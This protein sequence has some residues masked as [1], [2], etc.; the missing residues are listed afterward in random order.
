M[1]P[2]RFFLLPLLLLVAST[3]WARIAGERPVSDPLYGLAPGG[4][5]PPVVATDGDGFLTVWGDVRSWPDAIYAARL[6][7]NGELLDPTDIRIALG[8]E[9]SVVF[10][11]DA[12]SILWLEYHANNASLNVARVSREGRIVDGP[13][14]VADGVPFTAFTAATNG[15]R[16]VIA[17]PER[18]YVLS[19]HSELLE[20]DI[21]IQND[22]HTPYCEGTPLA[23]S[24]GSGFLLA[25]P[26]QGQIL[27][28]ALDANGHPLSSGV[29]FDSDAAVPIALTTDGSNY[30]VVDASTTA[31]ATSQQLSASGALLA[32]NDL[33]G[34]LTT[35]PIGLA[36]NG[37]DYVGLSRANFADAPRVTLRLTWSGFVLQLPPSGEEVLNRGAV[38]SNGHTLFAAWNGGS[39]TSAAAILTERLD[40]STLAATPPIAISFSATTQLN[41]SIA[42]SGT[43]YAV[44]W[45]EGSRSWL[46]RFSLT[47]DP[48]DA[49]PVPLDTVAASSTS[50]PRIT[51]DGKNY[52]AAA[53]EDTVPRNG[54]L[55]IRLTRID[56]LTG[57]I[58]S[59]FDGP[60]AFV[61]TTFDLRSDGTN[62]VMVWSQPGELRAA[63]IGM[64][65]VVNQNTLTSPQIVAFLPSLAWNGT[66]WLVSF[67]SSMSLGF[68]ILKTT[69]GGGETPFE[70][71]IYAVR[72][73]SA[74][75][76]LDPQPIELG[77]PDV[78][79]SDPFIDSHSAS[80][81]G[82]FMVAMTH[83][84]SHTVLLRRVFADGSIAP[85]VQRLGAGVALDV[86]ADHGRYAV[87]VASPVQPFGFQQ[88]VTYVDRNGVVSSRDAFP[89]G[90]S[91]WTGMRAQ[92]AVG[93]DGIVAA[94]QRSAY[95]PLYGGAER[96]FLR[97]SSSQGRGRAVTTR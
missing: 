45:N 77:L 50:A 16:I 46:R 28:L 92:L 55:H 53:V 43:N 86:V 32:H 85:D 94:Y 18:F 49:Q 97:S 14:I 71:H 33:G 12:Y 89:L 25:L 1:T 31:N 20:R 58:L 42:F 7:A 63:Q 59:A 96:I 51:F 17:W 83:A 27:A 70:H 15:R 75:A 30:M 4:K 21:R 84:Q 80:V 54:R 37:T 78:T 36:W 82:D 39:S 5:R 2:P 23:A 91:V 35:K 67:T 68:R 65:D 44:A 57:Q 10:A 72:L 26:F 79:F 8:F 19:P 22:C 76:V 29:K 38:A 9:A 52:V 60:E 73:S 62:V 74:L 47:G 41:P 95:E 93:L 48:I 88:F 61:G 3:A 13:R 34:R 56:P 6:S 81:G 64:T 69:L 87:A 11:D 90:F 66:Q 40:P 24:N